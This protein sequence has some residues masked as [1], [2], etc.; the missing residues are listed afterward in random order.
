MY[1]LDLDIV[2]MYMQSKNELAMVKAFKSESIIDRQ[3]HRRTHT[4]TH[5]DRRTHD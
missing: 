3:T 1:R 5:T 2:G 4:D